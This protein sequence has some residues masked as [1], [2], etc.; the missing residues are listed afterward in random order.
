MSMER[1]LNILENNW[2]AEM[3]GC[4]T[5][6]LWAKRETEPQRRIAFRALAKAEKH[7]ADLWA[8]RIHA[9]GRPVPT[10]QGPEVWR[11]RYRRDIGGRSGCGMR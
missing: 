7:H 4:H 9:L 8:E 2:Q 10:Y 11:G 1:V 5:Y 6:A 3:R